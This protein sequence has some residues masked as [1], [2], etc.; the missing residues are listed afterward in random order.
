MKAQS[1][2]FQ[3]P[4]R[5]GKKFSGLG[6]D[7]SQKREAEEEA[8]E[9]GASLQRCRALSAR[10]VTC[11]VSPGREPPRRGYEGAALV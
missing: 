11:T 10:P 3:A 7:P 4:S 1:K 9:G 5:G 8:R 2:D 6:R